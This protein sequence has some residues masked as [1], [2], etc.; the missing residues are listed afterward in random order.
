M[1]RSSPRR[2]A[3][4]TGDFLNRRE[5][6][7][8]SIPINSISSAPFTPC[9]GQ[10]ASSLVICTNFV[11]LCGQTSREVCRLSRFVIPLE[12]GRRTV[13]E[14]S[15]SLIQELRSGEHPRVMAGQLLASDPAGTRRSLVGPGSLASGGKARRR[16]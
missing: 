9:R 15:R 1:L 7:A 14:E 2:L 11:E 13:R 3:R 4:F 10:N 5:N 12:A 6:A 16:D 8:W